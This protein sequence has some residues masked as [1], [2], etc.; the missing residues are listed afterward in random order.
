LAPHL[1]KFRT[2]NLIELQLQADKL[3]RQAKESAALLKGVP[4]FQ[5]N[6]N[7]LMG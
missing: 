5:R 4:E 6:P 1:E 7:Q 2:M 3:D